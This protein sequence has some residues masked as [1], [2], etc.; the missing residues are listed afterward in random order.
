IS[1]SIKT[2]YIRGRKKV[3]NKK[4]T[5]CGPKGFTVVSGQAQLKLQKFTQPNS[6]VI[7]KNKHTQLLRQSNMADGMLLNYLVHGE[8]PAIDCAFT[9]KVAK[10]ETM[11]TRCSNSLY[12]KI[13]SQKTFKNCSQ[14]RSYQAISLDEPAEEHLHVIAEPPSVAV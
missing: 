4:S 10:S 11:L 13:I 5:R 8:A 12:L 7:K 6:L 9:I 3:R 14:R 2:R 1:D